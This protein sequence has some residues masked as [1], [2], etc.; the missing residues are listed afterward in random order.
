MCETTSKS[1]DGAHVVCPLCRHRG[2][3][4]R[5]ADAWQCGREGCRWQFV[6]IA[7][8]PVD[9]YAGRKMGQAR[10][11]KPQPPP[12]QRDRRGKP[13]RDRGFGK[14][15]SGRDRRQLEQVQRD[16]VGE[17]PQC[18]G[19]DIR[20]VVAGQSVYLCEGCW[21]RLGIGRHDGQFFIVER[22]DREQFDG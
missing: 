18:R 3:H 8:R 20:P 11:V 19:R 7:G 12:S 22:G 10:K 21:A 17:C 1:N 4:V 15:I 14:P 9:R 5:R 2:P 6:L 16:R 13:Q